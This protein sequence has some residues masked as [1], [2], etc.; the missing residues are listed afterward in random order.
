MSLIVWIILILA[1]LGALLL[2]LVC[3][4][5][6]LGFGVSVLWWLTAIFHAFRKEPPP[7]PADDNWSLDQGEEVK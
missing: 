4:G 5:L 3:V 7:T 1:A 2:I 6:V